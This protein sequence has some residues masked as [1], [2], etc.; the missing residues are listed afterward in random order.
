MLLNHTP[1]AAT[2]ASAATETLLLP[3]RQHS[4][5]SSDRFHSL[6]FPFGSGLS[7]SALLKPLTTS[8]NPVSLCIAFS[9]PSKFRRNGTV[10]FEKRPTVAWFDLYKRLTSMADPDKDAASVLAQCENEG[11]RISKFSLS[12]VVKQLRKYKQYQLALEVLE[13]MKGRAERFWLSTGDI[14]IKL[15][16]ISK[17]HG[18]S[19]AED[20]FNTLGDSS[21]DG[22]VYGSLLNAYVNSKMKEKAE[23]VYAIMKEKGFLLYPLSFNVMMTLYMG[24]KEYDK[25]EAIVSEMRAMNIPLD[26]YSYNIWLT[27]LGHQSSLEKMEQVFESIKADTKIDIDWSTLSTMARMYIKQGHFE[28]AKQYLKL[29]EHKTEGQNRSPYHFLISLYG[30]IGDPENVRRIWEAYKSKFVNLTDMS[31]RGVISALVKCGDVQGAEEVYDEWLSRSPML[32]DP[33]IGNNLLWYYVRNGES[34][35]AET[36]FNQMVGMGMKPNSRTWEILAEHHVLG[37]RVPEAL[38]C[39]K[40][41]IAVKESRNWKPK[42]STVSSVTALCDEVGDVGSKEM[43]FEVLK[44]T[45]YFNGEME[46][47]EDDGDFA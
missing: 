44:Q 3:H 42:R 19:S 5:L 26:Q 32:L 8:G 1:T 40:D 46:K 29:V 37:R 47:D 13:W 2:V 16:L 35:K 22:R 34:E 28:K 11:I 23:S 27:S 45:G 33:R 41:A 24:D 36:F 38:S 39:L 30:S 14:A 21:K 6:S 12:R 31:Y 43:L 4:S 25:V 15:D 18:A 9:S 17:L 7:N 10:D 20:Y